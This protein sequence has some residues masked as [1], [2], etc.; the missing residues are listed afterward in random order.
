MTMEPSISAACA[1]M[2]P[3]KTRAR[4]PFRMLAII[5]AVGQ[6]SYRAAGLRRVRAMCLGGLGAISGPTPAGSRAQYQLVLGLHESG[7]ADF[8]GDFDSARGTAPCLS[9]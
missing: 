4:A 8:P 3:A 6:G 2:R 7:L 9:R 1:A 5:G